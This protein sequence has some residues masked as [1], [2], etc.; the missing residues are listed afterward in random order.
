MTLIKE[1]VPEPVNI[2]DVHKIAQ[3]KLAKPV[4]DYYVTGAD[5]EYTLARNHE[6][7]NE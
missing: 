6:A 4:W 1:P 7:Y 2:A 5:D 3:Q